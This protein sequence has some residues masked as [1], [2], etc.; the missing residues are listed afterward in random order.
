MER[1]IGHD[2]AQDAAHAGLR[3]HCPGD[4]A[5]QRR[6]AHGGFTTVQRLQGVASLGNAPK[7]A[8]DVGVS[9][10]ARLRAVGAIL[11]VKVGVGVDEVAKLLV[12]RGLG[13]ARGALSHRRNVGQAG[14]RH[15]A[16][17][18]SVAAPPLA[19]WRTAVL[20]CRSLT[21]WLGGSDNV[22]PAGT[23]ALGSGAGRA[24][25]AVFAFRLVAR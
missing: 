18:S 9:L 20:V 2:N 5:H 4:G 7:T 21:E 8:E 22:L 3:A 10:G 6:G 11:I 1:V 16:E 15:H 13:S 17:V 25:L 19:S 14:R 24:A 12:S 23:A